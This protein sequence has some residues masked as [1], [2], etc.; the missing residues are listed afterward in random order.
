MSLETVQRGER[1]IEL[2]KVDRVEW[3]SKPQYY[4]DLIW[5]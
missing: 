4:E 2:A 3:L 1:W 5:F